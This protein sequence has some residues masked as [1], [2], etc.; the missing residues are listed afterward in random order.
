MILK[1]ILRTYGTIWSDCRNKNKYILFEFKLII[2]F[3]E[4]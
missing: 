1:P 4:S 3:A 2:I